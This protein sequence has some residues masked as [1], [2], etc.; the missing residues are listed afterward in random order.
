MSIKDI[1]NPYKNWKKK[2]K[3]KKH[4]RHNFWQWISHRKDGEGEN[5]VVVDVV[6]IV[7]PV[8]NRDAKSRWTRPTAGWGRRRRCPSRRGPCKRP[9]RWRLR[10]GRWRRRSRRKRRAPCL[11]GCRTSRPLPWTP[12][13]CRSCP[14]PAAV[15]IQIPL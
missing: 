15:A 7:L 4:Q 3:K 14:L 8:R 9:G 12:A 10:P 2:T 5:E 1:L 11:R 6:D 13:R